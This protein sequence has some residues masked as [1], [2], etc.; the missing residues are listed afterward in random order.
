MDI[1]KNKADK[2]RFVRLLYYMNDEFADENWGR[3]KDTQK[4]GLFARSIAWPTRKPLVKILAYCLMSNHFHLLLK[5][6]KEGGV[7]LFMK[8]LGDSITRHFNEKYKEKGS[9]FQGAYKSRTVNSDEYLRYVAVYVMVKNLF[10][11]YPKGGL[12]GAMKNFDDA[13]EWAMEYPFC[14]LA[15][16]AGGRDYS[17]VLDKDLLGEIFIKPKFFKEFA[18][19]CILGRKLDN[20]TEVRCL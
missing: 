16:Y 6:I 19:D 10:E 5:E 18:R 15:D 12:K 9:I 11:L 8:K 7:S 1:V 20:F 17:I 13:W 14:S 2:W 3:N 4:R